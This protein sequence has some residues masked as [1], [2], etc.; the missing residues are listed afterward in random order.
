MKVRQ[1]LSVFGGEI[2]AKTGRKVNKLVVQEFLDAGVALT[3]LRSCLHLGEWRNTW[4]DGNRVQAR[5]IGRRRRLY[6]RTAGET[7]I[8]LPR[9]WLWWRLVSA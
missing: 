1:V 3:V 5:D 4:A 6:T 8:V 2:T 9:T 7:C